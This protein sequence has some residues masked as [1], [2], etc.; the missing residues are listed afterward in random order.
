[1]ARDTELHPWF[2]HPG[3]EEWVSGNL[4]RPSVKRAFL[5]CATW[6]VWFGGYHF[7]ERA[8]ALL[9]ILR[10]TDA[11][12]I[13]LQEVTPGFLGILTGESWVQRVY[14]LSDATGATLGRYGVLLLSRLPIREVRLMELPSEMGRAL[15]IA[16]VETHRGML[17]IG[18]VHL[19][20]LKP[21][22]AIRA[23]QLSLI[24]PELKKA[25][26]SLLMGDFNFCSTWEENDQLD[27]SFSDVWQQ[28]RP[29]EP[30][31][32][33]DTDI[34]L[35]TYN[36]KGKE[37]R[38]RFDR[39]LLHSAEKGWQPSNVR[40]LGTEPITPDQPEVFPSDHFGLVAD[41]EWKD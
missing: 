2:Y 32:T 20:S 3:I 4:P 16:D 26:Q 27:P 13:A 24:F 31:Y 15:V 23:R 37:K 18:T 28:L 40:L 25:P 19:E 29:A 39:I 36:D 9:R 34:N 10:R 12:L 30:G 35:M 17:R 6:N 21:N 38:V 41:F 5:R 8:E 22:A 7:A 33:E 14:E 11:D 1:M